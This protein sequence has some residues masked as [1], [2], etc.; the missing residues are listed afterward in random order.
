MS[1]TVNP[2]GKIVGIDLS[3]DTAVAAAGTNTQTLTPPLGNVY[4]IIDIYYN[5]PD[6]AGS[7]A[8]THELGIKQVTVT[9]DRYR[10]L[11]RASTG[12]AITVNYAGFIGDSAETPSNI[13]EQLLFIR[14]QLWASNTYP[15]KFVYDNDTDVQQAGTRALEILVK[16]YGERG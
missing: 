1:Y 16:E 15:M 7:A 2:R 12:N 5:A 4:Q 3:D 11:I 14:G 6:P 9:S 8:G 10:A 13:R